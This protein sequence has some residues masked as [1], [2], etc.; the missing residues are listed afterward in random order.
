MMQTEHVPEIPGVFLLHP[1]MHRD[2]RGFFCET[3]STGAIPESGWGAWRW[4]LAQSEAG[5]IRGLHVRAGRG[6]AKL[7]R[8]SRGRIFDVVLDLRPGSPAYRN[9]LAF[10]L[11]GG[12]QV[13]LYIPPGCAHGYQALLTPTDVTYHISG[14][15]DPA[16]DVLIAH[17]DPELGIPWPL[18]P[19]IL[20][21]RD[22][23]AR[24]LAEAEKAGLVTGGPLPDGGGAHRLEPPALPATGA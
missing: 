8:C 20:S 12:S 7:V 10:W 16:E 1:D 13:S 14:E 23:T 9:W 11:D 6:E 21:E 5:V 2:E 18:L 15:H 17:D 19:A 3:G 24:M 22:R 4:C